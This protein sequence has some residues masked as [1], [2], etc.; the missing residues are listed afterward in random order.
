MKAL[1]AG[2]VAVMLALPPVAQAATC[3][4]AAVPL[5][6]SMDTGAPAA[7]RKASM[8]TLVAV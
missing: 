4:C 8:P 7:G 3:S 1:R 5:L 6:G 2:A